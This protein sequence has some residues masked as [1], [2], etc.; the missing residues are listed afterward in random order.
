MSSRNPR[1]TRGGPVGARHRIPSSIQ[2]R[3]SLASQGDQAAA[4]GHRI[5]A[6]P[7]QDDSGHSKQP[8]KGGQTLDRRCPASRRAP[9]PAKSPRAARA[10]ELAGVLASGSALPGHAESRSPSSR[11]TRPARA[12]CLHARQSWP[13]RG[14]PGHR[15]LPMPWRPLHRQSSRRKLASEDRFGHHR[16]PAIRPARRRPT[17][18]FLVIRIIPI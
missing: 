18:S 15:G 5:G 3:S 14:Q 4:V 9:A 10:V 11:A 6:G 7:D 17:G 13:R 16:L 8:T 2:N 1:S 12:H